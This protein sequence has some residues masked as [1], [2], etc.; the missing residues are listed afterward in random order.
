MP[1]EHGVVHLNQMA[2]TKSGAVQIGKGSPLDSA[3]IGSSIE[4]IN[5][6]IAHGPKPTPNSLTLAQAVNAKSL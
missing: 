2:S 5:L 6:L 4:I 1:T 3:I